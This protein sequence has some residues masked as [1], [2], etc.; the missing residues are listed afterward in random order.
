MYGTGF[1]CQ[2]AFDR[3]SWPF[4]F[5][6]LRKYALGK[7]FVK[8]VQLLCSSP[9]AS[10]R[11]NGYFS[12][13]FEL[14]KG[15]RQGDP[16]SPLLFAL[17]IEPLTQLI[18]KSPDISGIEVNEEEHR[19]SLYAD[20]I[21]MYISDPAKCIPNLMRCLETFGLYS[22][23]KINVSKTE[24]FPMNNLISPQLKNVLLFKWPREGIRYLG[25]NI[26]P[27]LN[28]YKA[29]YTKLVEKN[30][31]D[32]NRWSTLP[33]TLIGRVEIIRIN[34]LP[35]FLFL[36]QTLPIA[37]PKSM[38]ILVDRLISPFIW[39]GKKPWVRYKVPQLAK[40]KGGI[41]NA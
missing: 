7:G 8:W 39:H 12:H 20:D 16:L 4:L 11:T 3:V 24:A 14:G 32:I 19:L 34:L 37:P 30:Q 25:I 2:K 26:S 38:F 9:Q 5:R 13:K 21:I 31:K 29:N 17:R 10:V 22:G 27:E 40:A 18:R 15:C 36:F 23:Y 6:A 1:R 28:L 33:L 35:R 41:R